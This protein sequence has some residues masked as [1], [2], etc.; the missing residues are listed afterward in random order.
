[1]QTMTIP[2]N[3]GLFNGFFLYTSN[4]SMSY[5][6]D[7]EILFRDGEWQLWTTIFNEAHPDYKQ[8]HRT[9][10]KAREAELGRGNA[11]LDGGEI[12]KIEQPL[13]FDPT[14]G[15]HNY[16]I[17]VR[18]DHIAFIV[19]NVE[20]SRWD[21]SFEMIPLNL[22]AGTFYPFWL[23]RDGYNKLS[24]EDQHSLR[25]KGYDA[26]RSDGVMLGKMSELF[27]RDIDYTM[28]IKKININRAK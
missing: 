23:N 12:F 7:V 26:Y 22:Y 4:N 16:K 13:G 20:R 11:G 21:G 17:D 28:D 14:T 8:L 24:S 19:D 5:E 15:Y 9:L 1:M 27:G 25:T 18:K 3:D 10:R 2:D 6:I